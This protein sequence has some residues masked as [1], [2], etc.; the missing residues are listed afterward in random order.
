VVSLFLRQNN[1]IDTAAISSAIGGGDCAVPDI[2]RRRQFG[3]ESASGRSCPMAAITL[4]PAGP[5]RLY[6]GPACRPRFARLYQSAR[7]GPLGDW[8]ADFLPPK[9]FPDAWGPKRRSVYGPDVT[10]S[11]GCAFL[12][13]QSPDPQKWTNE[14]AIFARHVPQTGR[15]ELASTW[16]A[17]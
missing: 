4:A 7:S 11:N 16:A 2:G 6:V 5:L 3:K 12:D 17:D 10:L 9:G 13:P 15:G 1:G 8:H 14:P